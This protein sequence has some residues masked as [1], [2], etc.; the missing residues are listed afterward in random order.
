MNM[1]FLIRLG[2]ELGLDHSLHL[3]EISLYYG[4]LGY[5]LLYILL[6]WG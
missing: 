4:L 2:L 1:E 5:I 6:H 3:S